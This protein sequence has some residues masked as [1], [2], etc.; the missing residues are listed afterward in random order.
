MEIDDPRPC[1]KGEQVNKLT[2]LAKLEKLQSY[3]EKLCEE[4]DNN[5]RSRVPYPNF[6]HKISQDT[7][8]LSITCTDIFGI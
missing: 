4:K 6:I 2:P 1:L 3:I 5:P 8:G 7:W